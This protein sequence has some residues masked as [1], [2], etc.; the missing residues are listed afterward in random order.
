MDMI[1]F[2]DSYL[3]V[4][5]LLLYLVNSF[6]LLLGFCTFAYNCYYQCNYDYN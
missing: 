5:K 4:F 3:F 6:I 1:Y 2:A